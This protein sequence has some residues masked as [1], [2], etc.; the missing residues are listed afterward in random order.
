MR[1]RSRLAIL[2]A[3]ALTAAG[4]STLKTSY[5]ADPE[6]DFST[7][8]TYAWKPDPPPKTGD[9]R[10]DRDELLF[11]RIARA[12]DRNLDAKGYKETAIDKADFLIGYYITL[13]K[14]V[15][16]RTINDYYG[17]APAWGYFYGAYPYG[18]LGMSETYVYQYDEG[19]LVL[20]IADARES[21]LI[22]RGLAIDEVTFSRS[23]E[24]KEQ[25]VNDAIDKMLANFP[26]PRSKEQSKP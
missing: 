15:A 9:P 14:K 8:E 2:I 23:P 11:Q 25:A 18:P 17:W 26:P 21:R 16:A 19:T 5:D 10:V 4:C 24:K 13:E 1:M 7:L 12:V 20:D 3:V 6:F 22:W